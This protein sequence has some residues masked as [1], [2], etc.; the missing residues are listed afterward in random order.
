MRLNCRYFF[1]VTAMAN[2]SYVL[3]FDTFLMSEFLVFNSFIS[4]VSLSISIFGLA[5]NTSNII[6]FV[7]IGLRDN[8]TLTL[9]F[10]SLSDL[11][12]LMLRCPM[13]VDAVM[14]LDYPD[15][16]WPFNPQILNAGIYWYAYVF[17]DYSSFISVFLALVRC[18]CVARPLHFKSTFTSQRTLAILGF[19][20]LLA[21]T[22][23]IPVLTIIRLTWGID[24]VTNS[25]YKSIFFTD[26]FEKMLKANDIINR[27]IVSWI[28]YITVT[29][30]VLILASKL[31]TASRF[32]QSLQNP[33]QVA[34]TEN[35]DSTLG[36]DKTKTGSNPFA[37]NMEASNSL[38]A[39]DIQVI[40]SVTLVCVVFILSQLP[41]QIQ[42]TIRLVDPEFS[43][44]S[45]KRVA[46][47]FSSL[48]TETFVYFNASLNIFVYYCFNSRYRE[49]FS[50]FFSKRSP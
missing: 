4:H 18:A 6:M 37:R 9:L 31:Q 28:A 14:A 48:I 50:R 8:V 47:G 35:S 29:T 32:R 15:H 2:L 34:S 49:I 10:L 30:C 38:S 25:T 11:L 22:L 1:R 27:N 26:N 42:S 20:F 44:R 3:M 41:S 21:L 23:R 36:T 39:R 45:R 13:N 5:S 7:K 12:N 17:Y 24:P 40:K 33:T 19:L 43:N 16:V 46:Y